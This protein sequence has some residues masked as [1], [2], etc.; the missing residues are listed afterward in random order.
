MKWIGQQMKS[1]LRLFRDSHYVEEGHV[2]QD[3]RMYEDAIVQVLEEIARWE[4][5]DLMYRDVRD[6]GDRAQFL[7][8]MRDML[9]YLKSLRGRLCSRQSLYEKGLT[10]TCSDL[11]P[12]GSDL[13]D[14]LGDLLVEEVLSTKLEKMEIVSE[15][16]AKNMTLF[17][18]RDT[19]FKRSHAPRVFLR[20]DP[21]SLQFMYCVTSQRDW[22]VVAMKS[23]GSFD[24]V[25]SMCRLKGSVV[26]QFQAGSIINPKYVCAISRNGVFFLWVDQHD[27]I[28]QL[29]ERLGK[30]LLCGMYN[31]RFYIQDSF[32]SGTEIVRDVLGISPL[33]YFS[34]SSSVEWE[35]P[36]VP[37]GGVGIVERYARKLS[38]EYRL[39][40]Q[41]FKHSY[42]RLPLFFSRNFRELD[43]EHD[44]YCNCHTM[45]YCTYPI[46][47]GFWRVR[48]FEGH[49]DRDLCSL[50]EDLQKKT[51]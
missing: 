15:K 39:V 34:I 5:F 8:K 21:S 22:E 43:C 6:P 3:A 28:F 40:R 13:Y 45:I 42:T 19:V 12:K 38:W 16:G 51:H 9:R 17:E 11:F 1:T 20:Q 50:V 27:T 29:Q 44:E 35:V 36:L 14:N 41:L 32:L 47:G 31:V 24:F 48:Y 18:F 25:K 26:A 33:I 23:Y 30:Y 46:L 7:V 4:K 37:L 49:K 10:L 2:S